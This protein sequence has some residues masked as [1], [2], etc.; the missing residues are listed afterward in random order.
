VRND[1]T[2]LWDMSN[3]LIKNEKFVAQPLTAD[4]AEL[5]DSLGSCKSLLKSMVRVESFVVLYLDA[6]PYLKTF[7]LGF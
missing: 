2:G 5:D 6:I 3:L 1:V 7:G 4:W